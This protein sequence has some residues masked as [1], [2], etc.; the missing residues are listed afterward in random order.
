[1]AAQVGVERGVL[2]L[3]FERRR[4]AEV[5][6]VADHDGPR[7]QP[8]GVAEGPDDL[9]LLAG[10]R[11]ARAAQGERAAVVEHGR[12]A[13]HV[14]DGEHH[15]VAAMLKVVREPL[16]FEQARNEVE[17]A[18]V[19][20]NDVRPHHPVLDAARVLH[21]PAIRGRGRRE[22]REAR[23]DVGRLGRAEPGQATHALGV[24]RRA[25]LQDGG[26]DVDQ[27][28]LEEVAAASPIAGAPEGWDEEDTVEDELRGPVDLLGLGEDAVEDAPTVLGGNGKRGARVEQRVE[29]GGA[30]RRLPLEGDLVTVGLR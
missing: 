13:R 15:L 25:V 14:R 6:P 20:L 12:H 23:V 30:V 1:M 9:L 8:A 3:R 17:V 4:A 11:R 18:L 29:V 21:V 10:A 16:V 27:R 26:D 24:G 2:V 19:V 22:R 7:A 28:L 5:V